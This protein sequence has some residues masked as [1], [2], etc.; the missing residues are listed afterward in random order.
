[1]GTGRS[2]LVTLLRARGGFGDVEA[3]A[4][5]LLVLL[6]AMVAGSVSKDREDRVA[7]LI[8]RSVVCLDA[9]ANGR[10]RGLL[11]NRRRPAGATA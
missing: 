8:E 4:V 10:S 3:E 7:G 5:V 6:E 1:M 9:P 11:R 2:S